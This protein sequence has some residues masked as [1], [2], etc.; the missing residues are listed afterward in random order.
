MLLA[1]TVL[2]D[3]SIVRNSKALIIFLGAKGMNDTRSLEKSF[4]ND[5]SPT[6]DRCSPS[7]E[8]ACA[9]IQG[10]KYV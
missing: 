1:C 3:T 9:H 4:A 2:T 8:S 7:A 5:N 6:F 10:N